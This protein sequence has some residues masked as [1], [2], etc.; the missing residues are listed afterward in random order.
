[1]PLNRSFVLLLTL[2]CAA[3]ACRKGSTEKDRDE[4]QPEVTI[5]TNAAQTQK[6]PPRSTTAS[7]G[8][9]P[10]VFQIPI[11]PTLGILPGQGLG[12]IRFGATTQTIE[13]LM[14]APCTEKSEDSCRYLSQAVDFKLKDGVL[15]EIYV[16]GDERA[17]SDRPD[18][19]YGV[20]NGRFVQGPALGMYSKFV[21][22]ALGEPSRIEKVETAGRFPTL[23]RHHYPD[24]VL[25]YDKLE[26]GNVV[27][28][29][30]I[31]TR[32]EAAPTPKNP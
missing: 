20:F 2:L 22:E 31:L 11:G 9:K 17:F 30:V 12:P 21:I 7:T 1:M 8:I 19:T 6:S 27:L 29:G 16:H 15:V 18:D 24:M 3:P 10:P 26:N 13:R 4:D 25:E 28:A 14:E 5:A 23:E 32:S